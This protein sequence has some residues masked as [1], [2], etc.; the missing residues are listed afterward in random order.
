M[1][2]F[3][4]IMKS[5]KLALISILVVLGVVLLVFIVD[6]P[7]FMDKISRGSSS[8]R[9]NIISIAKVAIPL[10]D[11]IL[12]RTVADK[13]ARIQSTGACQFCDLTQANMEGMDLKGIDL[14]YANLARANL[15][16]TNLTG[17]NLSGVD[18]SGKDLRGT[19]LIGE[20]ITGTNLSGVNQRANDM[21]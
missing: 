3:K 13:L 5:H 17:A 16:G 10:K 11:R 21:S 4:K 14:R 2:L 1:L 18:L 12:S 20:D 6:I 8:L 9:E 15:Y 7:R 19:I